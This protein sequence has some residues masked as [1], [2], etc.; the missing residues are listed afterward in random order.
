MRKPQFQGLFY[1]KDYTKLEKEIQNNFLDSLGPG[2]FPISRKNK[3]IKS[4]I[5]PHASYLFSGQCAAWAYKEIAESKIPKAYV[6]IGP[7]H[8]KQGKVSVSVDD[9]ETPFGVLKVNQ[10]IVK[11]LKEKT[12][13][14]ENNGG[15]HNDDHSVEVQLP[16]LQF[17]NKDKINEIKIVPLLIGKI[18]FEE[19]LELG[20]A[21]SEID[22]ITLI[23]STDFTHYGDEFNYKPFIYSI[24]NNIKNIDSKIF[25]FILNQDLARL[26]E[27]VERVKNNTCGI[28]P[29]YVLLKFCKQSFIKNSRL[30]SYY[31]SMDISGD[32]NKSV[33]YASFIFE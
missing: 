31:N 10:E 4:I 7:H 22:D 28:L 3:P 14:I 13:L 30:L 6:I 18:S 9:F 12:E 27:Y 2:E 15:V 19:C 29:I 25:Q 8:N 32:K 21:L 1:P 26:K 23:I 11:E 20:E 5:V 17:V 33:S 16:F 24:Q